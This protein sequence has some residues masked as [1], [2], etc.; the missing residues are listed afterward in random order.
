MIQKEL[1]GSTY[2]IQCPDQILESGNYVLGTVFG[3]PY[4]APTSA[5]WVMNFLGAAF[6]TGASWPAV[7]SI[8]SSKLSGALLFT[9]TFVK[10]HGE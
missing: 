10:H 1:S 3:D 5:F 7:L 8:S 9:P 4:K 6:L 2:L